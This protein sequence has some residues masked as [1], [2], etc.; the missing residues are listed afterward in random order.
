LSLSKM[1]FCLCFKTQRFGGWI[2]FP[3]SGKAYSVR[4]NR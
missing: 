2:L 4:S 3:T 1:S